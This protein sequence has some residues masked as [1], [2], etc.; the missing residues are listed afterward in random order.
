MGMAGFDVPGCYDWP[1]SGQGPGSTCEPLHWHDRKWACFPRCNV[2]KWNGQSWNGYWQPRQT[3][4]VSN[5]IMLTWHGW[6]SY[7]SVAAGTTPIPSIKSLASRNFTK[8]ELVEYVLRYVALTT[9]RSSII[10]AP[11]LSNFKIFPFADCQSFFGCPV[12]I[13]RRAILRNILAG[14]YQGLVVMLQLLITVPNRKHRGW[15]C[16]AGLLFHESCSHSMKV[17]RRLTKL[18]EHAV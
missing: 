5:R 4:R 12:H 11:P 13:D 1:C 14:S 8:V 10:Q 7:V 2:T 6:C 17:C 3:C 9:T 15:L 16:W 18:T